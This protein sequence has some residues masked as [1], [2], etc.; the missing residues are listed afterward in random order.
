MTDDKKTCR[1]C[2]WAALDTKNGEFRCLKQD[3]NTGNPKVVAA[4]S[5]CTIKPSAWK[6]RE[7]FYKHPFLKMVKDTM[8]NGKTIP[9]EIFTTWE[10]VVNNEE[11]KEFLDDRVRELSNPLA[12][13]MS[14]GQCFNKAFELIFALGYWC[15]SEGKKT[16][17][18]AA[19][20]L[21]KH[22]NIRVLPE[23]RTRKGGKNDRKGS[24]TNGSDST[25]SKE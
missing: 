9:D 14:Q 22:L 24:S 11:I 4:E 2:R 8:K 7:K 12:I 1:L 3:D 19:D 20:E 16:A 18:E 5:F 10:G 23:K 6:T 21:L 17:G 13:L 15:G 25:K